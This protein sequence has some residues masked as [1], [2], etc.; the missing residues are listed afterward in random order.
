MRHSTCKASTGHAYLWPLH[1]IP[2]SSPHCHPILT[3]QAG[4]THSLVG[5]ARL[6]HTLAQVAG[7]AALPTVGVQVCGACLLGASK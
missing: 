6:G 3:V 2:L 4:L 1:S 7:F 5:S